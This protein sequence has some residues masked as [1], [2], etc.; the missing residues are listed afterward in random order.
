ML[1]RHLQS[2][3]SYYCDELAKGNGP[4]LL[5]APKFS[6]I[7]ELIH[8]DETTVGR[9]ISRYTP[10]EHHRHKELKILWDTCNDINMMR[11]YGRKHF[12]KL[13]HEV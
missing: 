12:G 10:L 4:K 11:E 13:Y 1:H 9:A 3:Y 5:P 7:A 6:H 2:A 8:R